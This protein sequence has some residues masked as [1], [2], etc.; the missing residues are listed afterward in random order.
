[1]T[2]SRPPKWIGGSLITEEE[3]L[4][5]RSNHHL[6]TRSS[7]LLTYSFFAFNSDI[8]KRRSGFENECCAT[9]ARV[10]SDVHRAAETRCPKCDAGCCTSDALETV[11][12]RNS[13][14]VQRSSHCRGGL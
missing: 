8:S 9:D 11:C 12:E 14:R 1:M 3:E 7:T 2:T 5:A 10:H 4:Q 13:L 6:G